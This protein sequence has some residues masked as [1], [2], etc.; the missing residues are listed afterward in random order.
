M[1]KCPKCGA[2]PFDQFLP[3]QVVRFDWFGLRTRV[4]AVI[5]GA[6]KAI[7]GHETAGTAIEKMKAQTAR[8][9]R[10]MEIPK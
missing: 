8:W 7:V 6:C 9:M 5:C 2:Q 4:F 10:A 1:T 3:G